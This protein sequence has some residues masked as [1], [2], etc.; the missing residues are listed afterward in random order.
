[1]AP[2]WY[3]PPPGYPQP[4]YPPPGYPPAY[5]YPPPAYAAPPSYQAYPPPPLPGTP[6]PESVA[7]VAAPPPGSARVPSHDP[8]ADRG[9]IAPTAYT[10]PRGTFYVSDYDLAFLQ[11]GYAFT[12]DTQLSITGVPPLGQEEVAFVDLTLKSTIYRGGRVRVAGLGS[13]SGVGSKDFGVQGV[14]RAGGVVQLCLVRTSCESSVSISTNVA[15][16]GT[17]IMF[18]G[19]SGIIRLGRP[20]SLLAE[21]DTLVPLGQAAGELNGAL[22]GGGVRF[23]WRRVGFDLTLMRAL[24]SS[25]ATVPILAFTYRSA[26]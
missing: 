4:G 5:A 6:A 3:Y 25:H 21:L 10:H 17:L 19:A 26:G 1:V 23:H 20:V 12:D 15:L 24:G 14:G 11:L 18:N 2:P 9:I 22:A 16:M 8:Q 13:A 7:R